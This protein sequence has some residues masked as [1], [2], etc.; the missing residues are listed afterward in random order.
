MFKVLTVF[1]I[2]PMYTSLLLFPFLTNLNCVAG[3]DHQLRSN[4]AA[5]ILGEF[6]LHQVIIS[7]IEAM[8]GKNE[9]EE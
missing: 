5:H 7:F 6:G 4:T 8:M 1:C 2:L 3:L 9:C